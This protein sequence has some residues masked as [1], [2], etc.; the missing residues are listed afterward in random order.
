MQGGDG[1]APRLPKELEFE[2][3]LNPVC[4]PQHTDWRPPAAKDFVLLSLQLA[5]LWVG[6]ARVEPLSLGRWAG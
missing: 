6:A 4:R 5:T 2:L 1:Q 3:A